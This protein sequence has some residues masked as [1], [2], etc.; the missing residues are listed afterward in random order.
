MSNAPNVF[1]EL[2]E[3]LSRQDE[4]YLTQSLAA[5]FNGCPR[6][7]AALCRLLV[8]AGV[9]SLGK[10]SSDTLVMS[11]QVAVPARN[12]AGGR[13]RSILDAVVLNGSHH[14]VAI[15]AKLSAA[16]SE[17]QMKG[18]LDHLRSLRCPLVLLDLAPDLGGLPEKIR[19]NVLPLSWGEVLDTARRSASQSRVASYERQTMEQFMEFLSSKGAVAPDP[20]DESEWGVVLRLAKLMG[21]GGCW[22]IMRGAL[23]AFE[24]M[25][26]ALVRLELHR[27]RSWSSLGESGEW[28]PFSGIFRWWMKDDQKGSPWGI[29]LRAGFHRR[30]RA[31]KVNS[32]TFAV[33]LELV[34]CEYRVA[35][36]LSVNVNRDVGREH[37][38]S[39]N[40]RAQWKEL[41]TWTPRQSRSIFALE[42]ASAHQKVEGELAEGLSAFKRSRAWAD[43]IGARGL[44]RAR[45]K[46]ARAA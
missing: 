21:G 34:P 11:T 46:R 38:L 36:R 3:H 19:Q 15:E 7:R 24:A 43:A 30:A 20:I 18:H 1:R 42:F 33:E 29:S 9:R 41:A 14:I 4:N 16:T 35:P 22:Q 23:P 37:E 10:L 44:S 2:S 45:R 13:T 27:D 32:V 40:L 28:T 31:A 5:V 8:R 17:W 25:Q 26:K 39:G 6:F 12:G